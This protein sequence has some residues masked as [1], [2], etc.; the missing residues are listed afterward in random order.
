[1]AAGLIAAPAVATPAS[2][3]AGRRI[4]MRVPA[5]G[6]LVTSILPPWLTTMPCTTASPARCLRHR[7]RGEEGLEDALPRRLVRAAAGIAD[8]EPHQQTAKRRP[9]AASAIV[10]SATVI[11]PCR[12]PIACAA[13]T[14]T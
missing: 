5:P 8:R 1:M 13:L 11:V 6:A 4:S 14:T 7:L 12:S 2:A 9:R 10:P 3:Q